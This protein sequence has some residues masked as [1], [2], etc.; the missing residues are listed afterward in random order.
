M[1]LARQYGCGGIGMTKK[2]WI[3]LTGGAVAAIA[4]GAALA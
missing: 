2:F 1:T 3:K 4:A